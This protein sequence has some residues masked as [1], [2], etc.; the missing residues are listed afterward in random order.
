MLPM[1]MIGK[2]RRMFHRQDKSVR[3]IA[4]LTSLSRI[5]IRKYLKEGS[6][7]EPKYA[8][9]ERVTKLTPFH[10]KLIEASVVDA[11]RP[12]K[13]RRRTWTLFEQ[14]QVAGYEGCYSRVTDFIRMW[15][16]AQGKSISTSAFVPLRSTRNTQP[17]IPERM[18]EK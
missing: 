12:R 7:Q 16:V 3:E 18:F 10:E 8:R 11:L 6:A 13:E 15:R 17:L 4:R 9:G 5:T 1:T 14:L 2:V